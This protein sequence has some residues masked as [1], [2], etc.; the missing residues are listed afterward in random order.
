MQMRKIDAK[1]APVAAHIERLSHDGRGVAH[2]NGKTV[3]VSGGL[4][5]EEA[6]VKIKKKRASYNEGEAI[7]V[8]NLSNLREAPKCQH[9]GLCGGCNLQHMNG[10]AQIHHKQDT[11]LELLAHQANI[12]PGEIMPPLLGEKWGYRTKARLGVKYVAG[13]NKVLVGFREKNTRHLANCNARF[14]IQTSEKN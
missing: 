7:S 12:L 13:K 6:L 5:G 10:S 3:F 11:V 2:I 4:P 14:C 8:R 9:F 1:N